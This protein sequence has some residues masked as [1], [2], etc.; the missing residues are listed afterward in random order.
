MFWM[1]ICAYC[2]QNNDHSNHISLRTYGYKID[3]NQAW[4][5][6]SSMPNLF[7]KMAWSDETNWSF[8]NVIVSTFEA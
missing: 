1:N 3:E 2:A 5:F 4:F 6:R 8:I 7:K